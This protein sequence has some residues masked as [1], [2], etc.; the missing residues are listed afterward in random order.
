MS[1]EEEYERMLYQPQAHI[2]GV[3]FAS[4][5]SIGLNALKVNEMMLI[6]GSD[7]PQFF[8][9]AGKLKD[10]KFISRWAKIPVVINGVTDPAKLKAKGPQH[11]DSFVAVKRIE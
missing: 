10:K 9:I 4:K 8:T 1:K 2:D 5:L 6:R 7:R 3:E 11:R